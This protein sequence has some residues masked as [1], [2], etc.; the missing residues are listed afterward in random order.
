VQSALEKV[1]GVKQA[2][3]SREDEEAVVK[4][5]L[6]VAKIDD[7]IKAVKEASGPHGPYDAKVKKK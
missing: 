3:I 7:L 6:D 5:D 1:K 4:Y 2:V